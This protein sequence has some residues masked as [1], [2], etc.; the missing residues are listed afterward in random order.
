MPPSLGAPPKLASAVAALSSSSGSPPPAAGAAAAPSAPSEHLQTHLASRVTLE[1]LR[2]GIGS[3]LPPVSLVSQHTLEGGKVETRFADGTRLVRFKNGT[4]REILPN[5]DVTVRF[6]NG[7]I[8]RTAA[9]TRVET[10][11]YAAVGTIQ[12]TYPAA[13]GAL[14]YDVF[15]FTA[16]KQF[17][18]H[19]G[20]ERVEVLFPDGSCTVTH[21]AQG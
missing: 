20:K 1:E 5:G 14:G 4:E 6:V 3:S 10:Y 9:A 16:T 11:F 13:A 21:A 19:A 17:E 12:T 7:D 15:E 2:R 18:L 8:K